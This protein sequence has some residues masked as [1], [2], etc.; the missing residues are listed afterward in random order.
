MT[1]NKILLTEALNI[2]DGQSI[3]TA[4]E[5][6]MIPGVKKS[7]FFDGAD[8]KK[9][10]T[11]VSDMDKLV[12]QVK[13][14]SNANNFIQFFLFVMKKIPHYYVVK[15]NIN[16]IGDWLDSV[17]AYFAHKGKQE[18]KTNPEYKKKLQDYEN[19]TM[20]PKEDKAFEQWINKKFAAKAHVKDKSKELITIYSGEGWTVVN[21]LT[22]AAAK[23]SAGMNNRKAEWCTSATPSLY[24]SYTENGTNKL[25]IIKN[26]T[27]NVMFQMDFGSGGTNFKRED[28]TSAYFSD[29]NKLNPPDDLLKA[30]KDK[31]G[32][33]LF[34]IFSKIKKREELGLGTIEQMNN[35][36]S[37][38]KLSKG[39]FKNIKELEAFYKEMKLEKE[40]DSDAEGDFECFEIKKNNKLFY[41]LNF[42]NKSL[43]IIL[44]KVGNKLVKKSL[45]TL[46]NAKEEIVPRELIKMAVP[47]TKDEDF[48]KSSKSSESS[49][50][51]EIKKYDNIVQLSKDVSVIEFN[52]FKK[53]IQQSGYYFNV[54]NFIRI[55]KGYI[56]YISIRDNKDIGIMI[57][58][59]DGKLMEMPLEKQGMSFFPWLLS[60]PRDI[61]VKDLKETIMKDIKILNPSKSILDKFSAYKRVADF[62]FDTKTEIGEVKIS[63]II[64]NK[65]NIDEIFPDFRSWYMITIEGDY[66]FPYKKIHPDLKIKINDKELLKNLKDLIYLFT[67]HINL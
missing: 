51:N 10:S 49:E 53:S 1:I 37:K 45:S 29:F 12:T 32:K 4:I 27:K 55:N 18:F 58:Y 59:K 40:I 43:N 9:Y 65:K 63:G 56:Q 54:N 64:F 57:Y 66:I 60:Y 14:K 50:I 35:G 48:A 6:G 17:V 22:F 5:K 62:K 36:W 24:N 21:P 19:S 33:S 20:E 38:R 46:L 13:Q 30:I 23:E 31:N 25:F 28:D 47:N 16:N 34:D 67:N 8:P 3:I 42:T 44:Q 41:F 2:T 26:P 15:S 52:A 61:Y 39:D 11:V 7:V